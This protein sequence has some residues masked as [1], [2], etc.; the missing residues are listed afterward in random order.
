M[1]TA[2]TNK[3]AA[4]GAS[5]A[6]L[7]AVAS[8][9]GAHVPYLSPNAFAPSTRDHVTVEASFSESPFTSDVAMK[10]DDYHVVSPNGDSAKLADVV[11]LRDLAVFEVKL[12]Q[13]GTYRISS[14]ER[15]GRTAKALLDKGELKLVGDGETAPASAKTVDYQSVT[16][17]ETYVTRG[18]PSA[19]ALKP[20]GRGLELVAITHPNEIYVGTDAKF[21]LLFDGEPV[22]KQAFVLYRAG[23][24]YADKQETP[25]GE[26]D[27][28]GQLTLRVAEPG[29]YLAMTRLRRPAPAGA[30]TPYRSYTYAL[31]FEAVR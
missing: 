19:G 8:P 17:A 13:A 29:V 5:L 4:I 31:T 12:P 30:Q 16:T 1:A 24:A 15:L 27:A 20:S 7:S 2:V 25:A 11:Y 22:K 10:S 6:L 28:N 21:R 26:T 3:V 9:A 23:G 18:A 14:G